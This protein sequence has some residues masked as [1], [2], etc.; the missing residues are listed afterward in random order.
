MKDS[1]L[2]ISM[3][4]ASKYVGAGLVVIGVVGDGIG[5]GVILMVI[6][7]QLLEILIYKMHYYVICS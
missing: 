6:W 7:F 1:V 2:Y 3:V 5:I 4:A